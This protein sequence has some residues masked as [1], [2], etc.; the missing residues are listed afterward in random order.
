[1]NAPQRGSAAAAND[2]LR[3]QTLDGD[4]HLTV[5]AD[6]NELINPVVDLGADD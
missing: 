6:V 4:D 5:A 2:T 3:I 1:M